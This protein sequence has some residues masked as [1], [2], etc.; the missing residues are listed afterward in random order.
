MLS[1]DKSPQVAN[2]IVLNVL[3]LDKFP[4]KQKAVFQNHTKIV[5]T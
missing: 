2:A 5:R 4:I 1:L 3:L